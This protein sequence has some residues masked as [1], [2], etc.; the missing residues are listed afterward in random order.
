MAARAKPGLDRHG[1]DLRLS[2]GLRECRLERGG[3]DDALHQAWIV[4]VVRT[5]DEAVLG[6]PGPRCKGSELVQRAVGGV[7]AATRCARTADDL[8]AADA[9]GRDERLDVSRARPER[10]R[11]ERAF[12]AKPDLG[13]RALDRDLGLAPRGL[14]LGARTIDFAREGAERV[15]VE[16]FR[17]DGLSAKA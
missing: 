10:T 8:G 6:K 9:V 5:H 12:A 15:G 2:E 1:A 4:L 16:T 13:A 7:Q 3:A 11:N 17:D 14:E